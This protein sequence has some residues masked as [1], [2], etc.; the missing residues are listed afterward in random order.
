MRPRWTAPAAQYIIYS[1]AQYIRRD[2]PTAA[3]DV[4][5]TIYD[6]C[7]AWSTPAPRTQG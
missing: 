5:K 4:A 6:G 2:N 1:I 7:E 3:R